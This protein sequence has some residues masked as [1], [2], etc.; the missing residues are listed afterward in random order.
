MKPIKL[1]L[2][3]KGR[4]CNITITLAEVKITVVL[5]A[6]ILGHVRAVIA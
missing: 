5:A 1:A 6:A 3:R 4:D 2:S